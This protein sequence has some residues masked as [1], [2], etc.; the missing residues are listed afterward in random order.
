MIL[1]AR[2]VVISSVL[3]LQAVGQATEAATTDADESAGWQSLFDGASMTGWRTY[4]HSEVVGGWDVR[5][6][7]ITLVESG[8]GD[9][10]TDQTFGD[11][12]LEFEWKISAGGNSGVFYKVEEGEHAVTYWTGLE[13]QILD[14][15]RGEGPIEQAGSLFALYPPRKD[16]TRPVG[17]FNSSRIVVDDGRVEHWI[18]GEC[19]VK[20]TLGSDDYLQRLSE[21]KFSDKPRFARAQRGHIALQDH[22]DPVAFRNIR[23][24]ALD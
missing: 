10:I 6:G 23:I 21:S 14:N 24:R 8:S 13:F 15:A 3:V 4:K 9:I 11:F 5:D 19:V 7:A 20:F 2:C 16:A 22:G 18:N 12:E 17:E 1:I